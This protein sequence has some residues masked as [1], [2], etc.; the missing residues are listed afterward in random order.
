MKY[1]KSYKDFRLTAPASQEVIR[2]LDYIETDLGGEVIHHSGHG[3][4]NTNFEGTLTYY[5]SNDTAVMIAL[6]KNNPSVYARQYLKNNS[7]LLDGLNLD[8]LFKTT[9]Y[10]GWEDDKNKGFHGH[11]DHKDN[12]NLLTPSKETPILLLSNLSFKTAQRLLDII[13]NQKNT[14]PMISPA[15]LSLLLNEQEKLGLDGELFAVEWEIQRLMR[16]K[17]ASRQEAEQAVEH[18]AFENAS[19]G[20]DIKSG[21]K[22]EKRFI[23]VKT[24]RDIMESNFFFSMNEFKVLSELNANAYIYRVVLGNDNPVIIRNPFGNKDIAEFEAIAFKANLA[25]FN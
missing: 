3:E 24:T 21:F 17:H 11:L 4:V 1:P 2:V 7:L 8:K 20:Y 22:G 14:T 5:F 10:T 13:A 15:D 9:V 12:R 19:L 25:D 23:E 16:E 6:N 18:V